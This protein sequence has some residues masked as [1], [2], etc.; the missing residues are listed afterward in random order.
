MPDENN[1]II[2]VEYYDGDNWV[3]LLSDTREFTVEHSG[4]LSVPTATLN[5]FNKD[6]KYYQKGMYSSAYSSDDYATGPILQNSPLRIKADVRGV[7]D[8]IFYGRVVELGGLFKDYQSNWIDVVCQ[9]DPTL[10]LLNDTITK[11]YTDTASKTAIEDF[12][13]NP[14]SKENPGITLET[15]DG[16]IT[17]SIYPRNL[18]RTSLLEAI[19]YVA[20][21][22][23][24]DGYMDTQ[25]SELIFKLIGQDPTNPYIT[26]NHPYITLKPEVDL[27][28]MKNVIFVSGGTDAGIPRD[29]DYYFTE[30]HPAGIW[31]PMWIGDVVDERYTT[32]KKI[33]DYSIRV[34]SGGG[35]ATDYGSWCAVDTAYGSVFDLTQRFTKIIFWMKTQ[36]GSTPQIR[37]RDS[38]NRVI[39]RVLSD[40]Y[41]NTWTECSGENL[42]TTIGT[43]WSQVSGS[44]FEW[45]EVTDV[46]LIASGTIG[47]NA[48][49]DGLK[50]HGG[51]KIDP[52]LYPTLNPIR[53]DYAGINAYGRAQV[54]HYREERIDSFEEA[55]RISSLL[56]NLYK[57]P[58]KKL[59]VK[60]GAKTWAKPHQYLTLNASEYGISNELWRITNIVFHWESKQK[61][62]RSTLELLPRHQGI[63]SYVAL[64]AILGGML[65]VT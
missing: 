16:A 21:E 47:D 28:E 33:G 60:A 1:P 19:R 62:L 4:I 6:G 2:V 40:I 46:G 23:H 61:V 9:E 37:L 39:G 45:R 48:Y 50:F 41:A 56:L 20:E 51:L 13:A 15:D 8:L 24:Y 5:L 7:E 18:E 57:R 26:L 38:S 49:F 3:N 64:L 35:G 29:G 43:Y 63:N 42:G 22:I 14:D 65:K 31:T 53:K 10:K 25:N 58:F 34:T 11:D 59:T 32:E 54:L 12:L 17:L 36:I 55:R 44:G 52:S 30:N 27:K